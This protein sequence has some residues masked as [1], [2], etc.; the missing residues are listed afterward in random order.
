MNKILEYIIRAKDATGQGVAS[1]SAKVKSLAQSV[2]RNLQN[3][4][5]GFQMSSRAIVSMAQS[6][7]KAIESSFRFETMTRQFKV[8]I[9]D[10]DKARAHMAMLKEL[11]DTPP[12]SLEAMA[13]ASRSLMVMSDGALGL[14]ESVVL[15]GDAAAATGQPIEQMA[16]EIGRA[17]A[18]IRDGQP[19]TRATMAL[20]NMGVITPALAAELAGLQEA[21]AENIV[22]WDKLQDALKSFEGAMDETMETGQGL[23]EQVKSQWDNS[24]RNFGDSLQEVSKGAL[25]R[26]LETLKR[27][28]EDGSLAV[29]ADKLVRGLS[30]V[31]EAAEGAAKVVEKLYRY[32]GLQDAVGVVKGMSRMAGAWAGGA[33]E[34]GR[35][36]AFGSGMAEGHYGGK[37]LRWMGGRGDTGAQEAIKYSERMAEVEAE[38]QDKARRKHAEKR[39]QEAVLAA[40]EEE[41][42]RARVVAAMA[43][44]QRRKD[45]ADYEQWLEEEAAEYARLMEKEAAERQRMLAEEFA[46]RRREALRLAQVE[47]DARVSSLRQEVQLGESM[48]R[49]SAD[50]LARARAQ[51]SRA[52]GWYRDPDAFKAQLREERAESAARAQFEKDSDRL[53]RMTNWRSRTLSDE[54]E[55]VRRVIFARQEEQEA[56]QALRNIDRN[57][58]E[59]AEMLERLLTAG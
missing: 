35:V 43:E 32:S 20:R 7:W 41:D 39:Q 47:H 52:W 18:I 54:Q 2:G 49:A 25:S 56:E 33:D 11:G 23:V 26:L 55:A 50:R 12:F 17:Y 16:Q 8:L 3:I 36:A 48:Q 57:T 1:A 22:I 14:R 13:A 46:E 21:G 37:L 31:R 45:E 38:A 5:A 19:I 6:V 28:N 53:R 58:A 34:G 9:G 24:I 44:A 51:V 30:Q 15:V 42:E 4:W 10:M 40:R 59:L 29:W 27:L